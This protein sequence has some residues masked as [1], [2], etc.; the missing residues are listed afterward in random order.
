MLEATALC[1]SAAAP[2]RERGSSPP[3][4]RTTAAPA[5]ARTTTAHNTAHTRQK[6]RACGTAHCSLAP[7]SCLAAGSPHI[8][9]CNPMTDPNPQPSSASIHCLAHPSH[10]LW[11]HLPSREQ[12]WR[13]Y[14]I[15]LCANC[16]LCL[17]ACDVGL[18]TWRVPA[19][20]VYSHAPPAKNCSRFCSYRR[21]QA[22][23]LPAL[24]LHLQ[25]GRKKAAACAEVRT[26]AG[27]CTQPPPEAVPSHGRCC[28]DTSHMLLEGQRRAFDG[29]LESKDVLAHD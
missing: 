9:C 17:S 24:H 7:V 5:H 18:I 16:H 28:I 23:N 14:S 15:R 27:G 8:A 20:L 26:G 6:A 29:A 4:H 11:I 12:V 10:L 21:V 1:L 22:S 3:A 13:P 19:Q 2:A 25:A